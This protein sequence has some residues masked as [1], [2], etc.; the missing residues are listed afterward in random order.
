MAAI[1]YF[2]LGGVW[3]LGSMLGL[4][5]WPHLALTAKVCLVIII[6]IFPVFLYWATKLTEEHK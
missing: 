4:V 6:F 1:G 5:W 3:G 2:T